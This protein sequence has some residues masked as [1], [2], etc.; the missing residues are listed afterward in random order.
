MSARESLDWQSLEEF[1]GKAD[2]LMC[3][4]ADTQLSKRALLLLRQRSNTVAQNSGHHEQDVTLMNGDN[5]ALTGHFPSSSKMG[6]VCFI[7]DPAPAH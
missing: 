2:R 5:G 1:A 4:E 7:R 6:R 3:Q